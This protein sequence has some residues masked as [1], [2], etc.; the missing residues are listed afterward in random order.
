MDSPRVGP[1][2]PLQAPQGLHASQSARERALEPRTGTSW[3]AQAHCPPR[4]PRPHPSTRDPL[5]APLARLLERSPSWAAQG[6]QRL[7][8][9]GFDGGSAI[10]QASVHPVRPTR[11]PAFLPLAWAPGACAQVAWGACGAGPVGHPRRRRRCFV[12]VRCASRMLEVACTVSQ[13]L[14]HCLACHHHAWACCGGIPQTRMVDTLPSPG[15]QRVRG[16]AP[17]CHP[18]SRDCATPCGLPLAPCQ[19]GKGKDK[20]RVAN[21]VG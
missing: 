20:G 16:A 11:P 13:T 4:T 15:L 5:Q 9:P 2:T 18:P 17:V 3:L 6:L 7:R 14:A 19:V 21:G 12:L 10:V 1:S 8:A